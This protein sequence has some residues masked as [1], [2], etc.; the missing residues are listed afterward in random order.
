M[1]P[2]FIEVAAPP[3]DVPQ[4]AGVMFTLT[5]KPVPA[6]VSEAEAD[7]VQPLELVTVSVTT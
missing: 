3:L 7:A 5:L 2:P 4:A 6:L 1:V